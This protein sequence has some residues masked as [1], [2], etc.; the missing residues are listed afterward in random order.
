M[1]K[2]ILKGKPVVEGVVEGE[3]LVTKSTI[4]FMGGIDPFSGTVIAPSDHE[5]KGES[6][7]GKILV[8]S[9]E[10]GSTSDPL[11]YYVLAKLG[12]APKAILCSTRGQMPVVSSIIGNTP[13]VYGLDK[14]PTENIHT[15]D[16]VTIDGNQGIVEIKK[17]GGFNKD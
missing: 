15:G 8:F 5:L 4:Q 10:I 17:C 3:A 13:F 7:S 11:G 9:A 16:R 12:T 6:I 14:N 1:E 2:L